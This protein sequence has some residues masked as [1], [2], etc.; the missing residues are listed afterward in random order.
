MH[1]DFRLKVSC[2]LTE[3]SLTFV[4]VS[5]ECS[6]RVVKRSVITLFDFGQR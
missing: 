6:L 3:C 1:L 4:R 5:T 2:V